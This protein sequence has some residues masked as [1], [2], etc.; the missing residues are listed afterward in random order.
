MGNFISDMTVLVQKPVLTAQEA[1]IY[2]GW[3]LSY[4][5]KKTMSKDVPH[6]KPNGKTLYFDRLE[7][8]AWMKRN[9]VASNDEI[10]SKVQTDI[11]LGRKGG[12]K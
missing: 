11:A 1:A 8:E 3:N 2:L 7:L 9:R 6:Y 5:Y 12:R 10:L 4:L